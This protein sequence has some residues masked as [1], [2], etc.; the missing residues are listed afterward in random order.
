MSLYDRNYAKEQANYEE[1][2]LQSARATFVKQTYQLLTA[3]LVAATAGAYIGVDYIKTFSWML[4]I[5]EFALLFG[6]MFSKKNPSLALVMLFGFTFVSGLTLGPVLNTYIGAG[7]GNIITQAFLMTAVAFG[8]LT[9]FAFNTKKDFSAMGK[10][11]FITLIVIVVASLLNLF[12]QSALLATVVAAIGAILFSAYI[13]YDTQMIIR[14]GY[15]SPVL[16]A[17]AL[18]LD[19]LNLFI[20]LLQL[21]GIFNKNE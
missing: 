19:I 13:L 17:V 8:G 16:A 7:M 5:V 14:G 15:D 2:G 6:L 20:S 1:A 12:F 21:L 3:S 9:V 11:L 4:L 10:M 18:Y